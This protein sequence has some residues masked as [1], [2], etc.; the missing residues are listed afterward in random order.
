MSRDLQADDGEV[1]DGGDRDTV[2][3]SES[4]RQRVGGVSLEAPEYVPISY[5]NA[6]VYCPRR[7]FY[8]Y[9]QGEMLVN[10]HVLQGR[11]HHKVSDAGGTRVSDSAFV[12]RRVYVFSDRLGISGVIDVVEAP[13]TA[14]REP[15][16][17]PT[18]DNEQEASGRAGETRA[19]AT[20]GSAREAETPGILNLYPIEYK[21]GSARG[22][23]LND[24]VQLCAQGLCLEERLGRE[25]AGGYVFSF[26]T[27]H[28]TWIPFTRELRT[29]TE[30]VIVQA[31]ALLRAGELPPPLPAEQDRKCRA[32]SLEPLCLPREVRALSASAAPG[33]SR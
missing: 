6:L 28:R 10:E 32:C 23:G 3:G 22:G 2:G 26:G 18:G 17:V 14:E 29:Q 31:F 7:F 27:M 13:L 20:V 11:I 12:M 30:A 9:A 33:S 1:G 24:S 8:E 25:L 19:R 15:G 21:K 4:R 16:T 5:L